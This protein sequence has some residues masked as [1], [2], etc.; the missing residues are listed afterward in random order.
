MKLLLDENLSPKLTRLVSVQ[1]PG[2]AHVREVSLKGA[3]DHQIWEYA[4]ENGFAIVSKDDDFRQRSLVEGAPPKVI[5]LKVGNAGT[6]VIAALLQSKSAEI[7]AFEQEDEAAI[8]IL[9]K[10]SRPE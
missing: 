8:L 3:T 6:S 5:W 1:Y 10:V 4:K 7:T 9:S 2:S